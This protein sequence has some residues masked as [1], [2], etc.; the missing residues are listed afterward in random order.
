[1][2]PTRQHLSLASSSLPAS[3]ALSTRSLAVLAVAVLAV[4]SSA[5]LVQ[6]ADVSPIAL[7]LWRTAG[8]ALVLAG[9]AIRSGT[10]PR[11]GQRLLLGIAGVAL[12]LHFAT[13]LASLELTSVAASVTL[14]S[15]APLLIA[16]FLA[17]SGKRPSRRTWLAIGAALAGTLVITGGDA[18]AATSTALAGDGLALAGAATMAVYLMVGNRLRAT[19]PTSA[20]ASR[21]Y[22]VAAA[23]LLPA[24]LVTDADLW[25]YDMTSWL[26]IGGMILGP[27][28]AGHTALNL[29]LRE[30]GSVTVSLALL[31]EPLCASI[32]VWLV[33]GQIPPV[34]AV[35]GAPLVM[36]GLIIHITQRPEG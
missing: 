33:F 7:S 11:G 36:A 30:L 24:A 27:Q 14:V 23:G 19:L 10:R 22:A 21:T 13:W 28:L 1:M 2:K 6:W 35:A 3:P 20:Y 5:V 31:A 29:L 16:A 26:A 9:P 18:T 4:S 34:A 12:G 15:S 17:L 25:G 32:L 8:G